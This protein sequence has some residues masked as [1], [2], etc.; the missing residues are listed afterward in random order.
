MSEP[1]T[2]WNTVTQISSGFSLAAFLIAVFYFVYKNKI[3]EQGK[4]IRDAPEGERV[5]VIKAYLEW[6]DVDTEKLTKQQ[7]Y[8]IA[9]RQINVKERRYYIA[10]VT[11]LSASVILLIGTIAYMY[12]SV[13]KVDSSVKVQ[14]LSPSTNSEFPEEYR[15]NFLASAFDPETGELGD[16]DIEW[17]D[18][19][20]IVG[21]GKKFS[22]TDF[23]VGKHRIVA[24]AKN[25]KGSIGS[26]YTD[27]IISAKKNNLTVSSEVKLR[28]RCV[29]SAINSGFLAAAYI[30]ESEENSG[31]IDYYYIEKSDNKLSLKKGGEIKIGN[32]E[33]MISFSDGIAVAGN[34]SKITFLAENSPGLLKEIWKIDTNAGGISDIQSIS[35]S[36]ILFRGSKAWGIIQVVNNGN[37]KI[38]LYDSMSY[39][40]SN[41]IGI[42]DNYVFLPSRYQGLRVVS[43]KDKQKLEEKFLIPGNS[44]RFS[45]NMV[46]KGNFGYVNSWSGQLETLYIDLP[47][48]PKIVNTLA[49]TGNSFKIDLHEEKIYVAG[50][51]EGLTII[52]ISNPAFPKL[53]DIYR[54][55]YVNDVNVYEESMTIC[56]DNR[57]LL[58]RNK[59]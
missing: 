46:F 14:I 7:A 48:P 25:R 59:I 2:I 26:N 30:V 36:E 51:G 11:F 9:I 45:T 12:L 22:R 28:G 23:S 47:N 44:E 37:P 13:K 41:G 54:F 58:I 50:K 21:A 42:Y 19:G 56:V 53:E 34:D 24:T 43:I 38:D 29:S 16:D 10:A 20:K 57:T 31:Y 15:I 8:E 6:F 39:N 49:G 27:F 35:K 52:N 17:T 55:G 5:K 3:K 18:N 32:P 33:R 40:P 4:I 1:V